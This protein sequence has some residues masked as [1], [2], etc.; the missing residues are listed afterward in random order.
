MLSSPACEVIS[1]TS[2]GMSFKKN[3]HKVEQKKIHFSIVPFLMS[4]RYIEAKVVY[5]L[6]LMFSPSKIS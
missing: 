2:E 6:L 1:E 5:S 4:P 3:Y